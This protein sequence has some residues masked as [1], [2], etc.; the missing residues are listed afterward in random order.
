MP[1]RGA[2]T[3]GRST[4]FEKEFQVKVG[5]VPPELSD[6]VLFVHAAVANTHLNRL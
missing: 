4:V 3:C 2:V 5:G 6:D 1:M